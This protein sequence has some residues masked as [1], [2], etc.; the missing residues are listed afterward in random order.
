[1][2]KDGLLKVQFTMG[3]ADDEIVIEL[4]KIYTITLDADGGEVDPETVTVKYLGEYG[5][6]PTPNKAGYGFMG[7]YLGETRISED[8][9]VE[10][11]ENHTLVAQWAIDNY[12]LTFVVDKTTEGYGTITGTTDGKLPVIALTEIVDNLDGTL[13]IGGATITA[14]PKNTTG[15]NDDGYTYSFDSWSGI[16]SPIT[17]DLTIVAKFARTPKTYTITYENID[18]AIFAESKPESYTIESANITLVN[19]TKDGFVFMGWTGTG[20]TERTE[21]VVI[22]TGSFGDRVYTAVWGVKVDV[23]A[24]G[25][26]SGNEYTVTANGVEVESSFNAV[27]GESYA[28]VVSATLLRNEAANK[29]QIIN[30]NFAGN[31]LESAKNFRTASADSLRT[32]RQIFSG[33]INEPATITIDFIDAYMMQVELDANRI[34]GF[35]IAEESKNIVVEATAGYVIPENA[36]FKFTVDSTP[37]SSNY[38]FFG[39]RVNETTSIGVVGDGINGNINRTGFDQNNN[40]EDPDI[41]THTYTVSANAKIEKLEVKTAATEVVEFETTAIQGLPGGITLTSNDGFH[42]NKSIDSDTTSVNLYAGTW[43][44][45]LNNPS[46]WTDA[47]AQLKAVFGDKVAQDGDSY[48]I[49]IP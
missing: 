23:V 5:K 8:S 7:W 13:T 45:T 1:M 22:S 39:F 35:A 37:K 2:N 41:G 25:A 17:G 15:E 34:S 48:V 26:E 44:V 14:V 31:G 12:T 32:T 10:L 47:L 30:M 40:A 49:T 16:V 24:N 6:L 20:L 27:I 33:I 3:A 46:D 42:F 4:H 18:D 11:T 43:T 28:F 9:I 38:T 19:P 21:N 29:Y 36:S